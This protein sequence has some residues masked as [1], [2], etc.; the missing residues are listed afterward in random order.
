MS[1]IGIPSYF[2][3]ANLIFSGAGAVGAELVSE[4]GQIVLITDGGRLVRTRVSEVSIQGRNTQ[5]V[6]LVTL[7]GEEELVSLRCLYQVSERTGVK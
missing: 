1:T 3:S 5:G 6:R 4:E 7:E 2:S